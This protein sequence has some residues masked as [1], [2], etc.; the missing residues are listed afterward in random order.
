MGKATRTALEAFVL[1]IFVFWLRSLPGTFW[2]EPEFF[3]H[4]MVIFALFG[5]ITVR[6]VYR[7]KEAYR[8]LNT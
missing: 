7:I 1:I 6:A 5:V 8:N 3:W 4:R 2:S